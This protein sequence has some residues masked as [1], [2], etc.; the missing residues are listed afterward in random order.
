M[1]DK[2]AER[3]YGLQLNDAEIQRYRVMAETARASE[4]DLWELAGITANAVMADVGCGPGALL[5]ALSDAVGPDGHVSAID[6]DASAVAAAS[7]LV[8]AAGLAN[9]SVTAGDAAATG[10]RAASFD[11]VMMRHVLAHN[12]G[13][14]QSI[15]DHLVMLTRPGGRVFLV[16]TDAPAFRMRPSDPVLERMNALYMRFHAYLGNDLEVGLRLPELLEAAGLEVIEFRGRYNIIKAPPGLRP[17]AWAAR[18]AMVAA[19]F[20]EPEDV[21]GWD[22]A[23]TRLSADPPT[24]Y[25]AVFSAVGRR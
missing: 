13:R 2:P 12:G 1:P 24:I 20:A 8:A 4:T 7:N 22:A 6:S 10:L 17:P 9:V 21:I 19:G 16:D 25:S 3:G 23:L 11:T 15:V 5:P 14:E 18:D